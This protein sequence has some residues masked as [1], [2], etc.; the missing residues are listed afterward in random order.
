MP[1]EETKSLSLGNDPA[2]GFLAP[3]E[4]V[5]EIIKAAT[6]FSPLRQVA[7]VRQTSRTSAQFPKRTAS[8]GAVWVS[9]QGVRAETEGLSYGLEEVAAHEMYALVDIS[10]Q[11][12]EDS[13]FDLPSELNGEFAEQFSVT[14][15]L[16]FISGN[17][18]GKP[19]GILAN[20]SVASTVS[21]SAATVADSDGTADGLFTLFHSLK[22]SY[23]N[24]GTWLLNK[25]TL[26]SLRKLKEGTTNAYIW[27][28]GLTAGVPSLIIGAPYLICPDMPSEAADAFPVAFGDWRRAYVIA[29][30]VNMSILRDPFSRATMGNIRYI[31]RKRVGGQ[32]V[33]AEAIRLLKCASS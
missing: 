3:Q 4:Y 30:R 27:Q 2:A 13:A 15:G 9:E 23:A 11:L 33:L 26:A 22:T 32:V 31:A 17:G 28:P 24:A 6:E 21:G 12:L 20:T 19:E 29:D 18:A 1:A 7:R 10:Q 5:L 14:E 8:F 16:A 25:T